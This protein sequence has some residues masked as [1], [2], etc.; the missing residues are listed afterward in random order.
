MPPENLLAIDNGTQSVRALLFDPLGSLIAKSQVIIEPYY[1]TAPGLAEQDPLVF[2]N[3]L[4]QAC[5]LL[6]QMPGV[7]KNS[8][9]AVALTTQRSTVISV[10]Q[11]GNALRPAISWLDQRRTKGLKPI[12]GLWGLLFRLAGATNTAAYL[13]AE[14]EASWIR[15]YQPEIWENQYKYLMLSGYLTYHLTGKFVDSVACQVG[16]MPFDYKSLTWS[17]KHDWKWQ[18]IPLPQEKLPELVKPSSMLGEISRQASEATGIPAGLPLMAA[19][20]DKACEVIGSGCLDPHIASLSYGTTATINTTHKRYMEVVPLIPPYPSAI[21]DQ[22][23]LEVQIY[24][25]FWMVSWFKREFG[26][27]EEIAAAEL[28]L[29]PEDLFDDLVD[30]VPPGSEGL[31]LQPYWSPGLRFPGPEARGAVIGFSDVHTRAHFY[32]AI[33]EGLVYGLREG[34]DRSVKRSGIPIQEL[35]VSGGGSQSRS[36]MQITADIFGLPTCRPHTFETSG[37]GAAI[38]AAV[39]IGI[40]PNFTTAIQQMTRTGETFEPNP[41]NHEKYNQLYQSVYLKMYKKLHP[42]Y[43]AIQDFVTE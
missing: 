14:A 20:A 18:V 27:K 39:G 7:E 1:S 11:N 43:D 38:D 41:A 42:L 9:A 23:T 22:Y 28:G 25:G 35:R 31:V 30:T 3:A 15:T 32:R 21:P 36:A 29:V 8:I 16:Y 13:Q 2:W 33:L 37:L 6:W 19:A 12:G 34:A 10:D 4:C 40:H 26:M 5:Q 24:R 17:K